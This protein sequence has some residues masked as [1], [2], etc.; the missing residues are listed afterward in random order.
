MP[1]MSLTGAA[2]SDSAMEPP[3]EPQSIPYS[4]YPGLCASAWGQRAE[5]LS[6]PK[7]ARFPA[8]QRGDNGVQAL[9]TK[10]P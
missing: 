2:V 4:L 8:E 1:A 10:S 3:K 5:T 9:R 6:L 7:G